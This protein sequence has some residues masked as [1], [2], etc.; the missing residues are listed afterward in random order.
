MK[1]LLSL[2]IMAAMIMTSFVAVH[3][4]ENDI[5]VLLDGQA[6]EFDVPPQI[7]GDRT[8]VPF[9]AIFEALG[10]KVDW[11]EKTQTVDA[12]RIDRSIKMQIGNYTVSTAEYGVDVDSIYTRIDLD[13][14]PMI[15]GDRTMVPVR[16]VAE[17]SH[18]D[19]QWDEKTYTVIIT[20][21]ENT[22][23]KGNSSDSSK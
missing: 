17:L 12:F 13:V 22:P 16:A 5:E 14:P 10:Y 15:I 4:D 19:V 8:L 1:K 7:V 6:I 18:Y 2:I 20:T 3:G 11:D 9:R 21:T 23:T